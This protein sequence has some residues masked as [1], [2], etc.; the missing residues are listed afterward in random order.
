MIRAALAALALLLWSGAAA[1]Q[2]LAA[3]LVADRIFVS[4]AGELVAEGNVEV[5]HDGTRLSAARVVYDR[6]GDRLTIDGPIL[7][8]AADG[9]IFEARQA[10]LDPRLETGL[11]LGAR[12][13]LD[14]QLQL[15]AGRIDRVEGRYSQ[16]S[17]VAATSCRVCDGRAP[18][19]EIRARRV[20]H[21]EEARLLYFEGAQFRV[22][23]VPV[24]YLPRL[25]LPDPTLERATGFLIPSIR[26]TDRLGIGVRL[27]YFLRLGNARDLTLT[28]Y[29]SAETRTLG[30]RY[31]QAFDT[32]AVQIGGA[33]TR[34]TLLPDETRGY[35]TA[36][37]AFALPGGLRLGFDLEGVSD[38]AYLLDY[39]LT[40]TDFLASEIAVFRV[41]DNDYLRGALTV[42][43]SL[44][45]A[46][47]NDLLPSVVGKLVYERRLQPRPFGGTLTF[48][49]GFDA[50]YRAEDGDGIG[51]DMA[52]AGAAF[53]WHGIW[54]GPGGLVAE[55]DARAGIDVFAVEQDSGF[56]SA[57]TRSL[58]GAATV[59]RWPLIARGA[60]GATHLVEPA[61]QIAWS[62]VQGS[63]VPNE[64][65]VVADFDEGNLLSLS[66]FAGEDAVET[67]LR[68]AAGLT[69][70]R[71]GPRGWRSTLGFGRVLRQDAESRFSDGTGL[72]GRRSDWLVAGQIDFGQGL[73]LGVRT[74][75]DDAADF[76]RTEA[77]LDWTTDRLGLAAAYVFLP[78]DAGEGRAEAVSEWTFD[79]AYRIST[80]WAVSGA[81]RYDLVAD[82]PASAR[83]G[84]EWRNECVEVGLSVSRRFTSSAN[85]TPSTDLGLSVE[86]LGFSA[87]GAR[88]APARPC[89][90]AGR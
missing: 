88:A 68:G 38:R 3:T 77:R 65:S 58:L 84:V 10:A 26:S 6:R 71:I 21:D 4:A 22:G 76:R 42:F 5:F 67:G 33:I 27:P 69:W 59:L 15:A 47:D 9:T 70:T 56:D 13:V 32:G 8:V 19:W 11:L 34:D 1:A 81:A 82:S 17:G 7:V 30:L 83:L 74:L 90:V 48:D 40:D 51:R 80:A 64:D 79:A 23:G 20:T 50:L 49:T 41:R 57:T 35:A 89:G 53:G 36:T 86:L 45:A 72:A 85:V 46:D 60:G 14:R 16:L 39:G 87:G 18:L 73:A 31:R 52:R 63:P 25:R 66:R 43:E 44:R 28:P 2:G 62:G 24:F 29:L 61:L 78:S 55:A 37:G 54:I 75:V 12:L